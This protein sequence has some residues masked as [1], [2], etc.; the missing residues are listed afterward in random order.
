LKHDRIKEGFSAQGLLKAQEVLDYSRLSPSE[1]A[2]YDYIQNIKSHERSQYGS[3]ILTGEMI[4]EEKYA[5]VIE[6]KDKALEEKDK[7]NAKLKEKL[8]EME[9]LLRD[10]QS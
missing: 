10:Q 3:A 7:E 6:E 4:A 5:G 8:A 1:K 2:E 9:R